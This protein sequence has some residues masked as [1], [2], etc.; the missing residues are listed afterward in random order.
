MPANATRTMLR[1]GCALLLLLAASTA[2][3]QATRT[4]VSGLGDDVNPC[5]RTA[6]CKTFAGAIS[7]TAPGGIVNAVDSGAYGTVTITKA[8]TIDGAGHQS[9]VLASGQNGIIVNIA[10]TEADRRVVLRGLNIDGAGSGGAASTPRTTGLSGVRILAADS[11]LIEDVEI[12]NFLDNGIDVLVP[13]SVDVTV[14]NSSINRIEGPGVSVLALA[15]TAVVEIDSSVVNRSEYGVLAQAR[16]RVRARELQVPGASI[17]AFAAQP[18][19]GTLGEIVVDAGSASHGAI[20]MLAAG[21]GARITLD[22]V[23]VTGNEVGIA[24]TDGAVVASFGDNRIFDNALD[25]Q[26]TEELGT[27]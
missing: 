14:R 15:G 9:G 18:A 6:P 19:V 10:A 12:Q 4:W 8:I 2:G 3:A 16:S 23:T 17:A 22:G 5:S 27:Q 11:V 1:T 24:V 20:G 13:G 21:P 25:G 7:K 26:P